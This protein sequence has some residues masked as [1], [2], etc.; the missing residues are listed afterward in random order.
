MAGRGL[1]AGK[2]GDPGLD[3]AGDFDLAPR[4]GAWLA[5]EG[6]KRSDLA[7]TQPETLEVA[8]GNSGM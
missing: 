2:L 5:G 7:A 1:G 8:N 6:G 4:S 3:L